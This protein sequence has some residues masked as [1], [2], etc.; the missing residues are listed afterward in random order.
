MA[1]AIDVSYRAD[2]SNLSKQ[3]ASIPGL[4]EKAAKDMVKGLESNIKKAE[5]AAVRAAKNSQKA[6]GKTTGQF[7]NTRQATDRLSEGME[8]LKDQSG[9]T[10][11]V[12]KAFGGA[13]G[14]V[15]PEAERAFTVLGDLSG[16]VEALARSSIGLIGPIAA[17]TAAVGA[18]VFLWNKYTEEIEEAEKKA[19]DMADAAQEMAKAVESFQDEQARINLEHAVSAG[20]KHIDVLRRVQ[21]EEKARRATSEVMAVQLQ[22]LDEA[23]TAYNAARA[24]ETKLSKD[25]RSIIDGSHA[26][27]QKA[28]QE[29]LVSL[30]VR[31]MNVDKLREKEQKLAEKI[32]ETG[33]NNRAAAAAAKENSK[34]TKDQTDAIGGLIDKANTFD[35][36]LS[37]F[38]QMDQ[39]LEAMTDAA[40]ESQEAFGRLQPAIGKLVKNMERLEK[41]KASEELQKLSQEAAKFGNVSDPIAEASDMLARLKTEAQKSDAAFEALAPDIQRVGQ[42]LE[43]LKA[44]EASAQKNVHGVRQIKKEIEN[45]EAQQKSYQALHGTTSDAIADRQRELTA[46]LQTEAEKIKQAYTNAFNN[47]AAAGAQFADL[48]VNQLQKQAEAES[49]SR[50][51]ISENFENAISSLNSAIQSEEDEA[52]KSRLIKMRSNLQSKLEQEQE[53]QAKIKEINDKQILKAFRTSQAFN[54]AQAVMNSAVAITKALADLGPI[55]GPIAAGSMG[56]LTAAQV[57]TIAAQEPPTAHTGGM[58]GNSDERLIKAR[59]GEG[60]LTAQGVQAIG[61]AQGVANANAGMAAG[62]GQ[63]VIQ[64]VYRHRVLDT[65]IQDSINKGGPISQAINR[66]NRR[67]RRNPY[68]RSG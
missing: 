58:V 29:A 32:F 49:E 11:S 23:Q 43:G 34:A 7:K 36:P 10:D 9:E 24:E 50:E 13:I 15:S 48:R 64:Q 33:E 52:E 19:K 31:Q 8:N 4:T 54:M 16:G 27:A 60:V 55:A 44:G 51:Q 25:S 47:M 38:Q 1:T 45:L 28:A 2:I 14:T 62:S 5:R 35:P 22:R 26:A 59:T 40:F 66:R 30:N 21:A 63:I 53:H 68:R 17:V 20:E 42:H 3:L 56:V 61:G 46:Q 57:A 6:W 65:V 12:L 67:G 18:G 41:A 37:E 39:L